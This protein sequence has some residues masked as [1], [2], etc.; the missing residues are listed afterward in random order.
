MDE[1]DAFGDEEFDP[2]STEV[3]T[4]NG[5][6]VHDEEEAEFE[7]D[8]VAEI[9]RLEI[10]SE[11]K[12]RQARA[13]RAHRQSISDGVIDDLDAIEPPNMLLGTLIPERSV[14]FL[15][16]RSGAYKSFLA[17]SWGCCIATGQCWLNLPGFEVTR[18]LKTLYVAAEGASGAAGRIRAW[19]AA[20]GVSRRGRLLV[21]PKA[22]HLNDPAQ[23]EELAEYVV[24]NNIEFLIIDTYHRSA[25]GTDENSSTQ[26][27]LVFEAVAK[28]RDDYGLSTLFVDHTGDQKVANPRGTSGKRDDSDYVLSVSYK[29]E[30]AT[31]NFQRELSITKLK[32]EETT[33]RWPIRLAPIE[34]QHFPVVE[35]GE[36]RTSVDTVS[37]DSEIF[38]GGEWWNAG[39]QLPD[40]IDRLIG[41]GASLAKDI[42]RV[43]TFVGSSAGMTKTDI[44]AALRERGDKP[45]ASQTSRAFALLASSGITEP[46]GTSARLTLARGLK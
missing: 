17:T 7:R 42:V 12:L 38:G 35:I 33:G 27:G 36:V 45:P 21:Y 29:G 39:I 37:T 15:A 40:M 43:M 19:E 32:D 30:A 18:P 44:V 3:A 41:R 26:F 4:L 24:E 31:A 23:V 28:M 13:A 9:R 46:V 25:P 10:R 8:V 6:H 5:V 14:G 1:L 11:A 20:N 34:G 22:I 2:F 16:G